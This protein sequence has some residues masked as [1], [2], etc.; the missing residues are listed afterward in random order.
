MRSTAVFVL[1]AACSAGAAPTASTVP[2]AADQVASLVRVEDGDSLLVEIDG[3]EERVRLIG[4]DAPE[5]GECHA[6]RSAQNL[7]AAIAGSIGLVGPERDRF[8]R[9]LSFATSGDTDLNLSAIQSGS[10]I[11]TLG[12]P[13]AAEFLAAESEA[14]ERR[15]GMWAEDACGA[16]IPLPDVRVWSVEADPPG[17]DEDSPNAEFAAVTN[18]GPPIDLTGWV[19]RDGTSSHRFRFPSGFVLESGATVL[20]RSGCGTPTPTD[21]YWCSEEPVWGN[22]GDIA[23]LLDERGTVVSHLRYTEAS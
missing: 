3:I 1:V 7:Q 16:T 4:I 14:A 10:A 15:L 17:R 13:R 23:L 6:D 9:I 19:L 8:G 5:R 22:Q 11:A 12:H 2:R 21:L 18:G 20:V